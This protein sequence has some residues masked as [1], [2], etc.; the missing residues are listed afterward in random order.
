VFLG[1]RKSRPVQAARANVSGSARD[2]L[3][4]TDRAVYQNQ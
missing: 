1:K 4:G 2:Y 3:T